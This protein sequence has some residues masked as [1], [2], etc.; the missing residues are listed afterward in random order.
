[1]VSRLTGIEVRWMGAVGEEPVSFAF[2]DLPL[3]EA[4]ERMLRTRNFVL[5]GSAD[6]AALEARRVIIFGSGERPSPTVPVS[7][8]QTEEGDPQRL[9][10][11]LVALVIQYA[12]P[13]RIRAIAHLA[14]LAQEDPDAQMALRRLAS[15]DADE[16]VRLAAVKAEIDAF[17]ARPTPDASDPG[18]GSEMLAED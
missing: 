6:R 5:I 9:V 13:D 11:E 4:L 16:T 3:R 14:L 7:S 10:D 12:V 8:E 15:E 2:A 17:A 18:M 1:E